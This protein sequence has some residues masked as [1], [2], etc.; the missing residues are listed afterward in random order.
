M[1]TTLIRVPHEAFGLPVFG[2][3]LALFVWAVFGLGLMIWLVR[4]KGCTNETLSYLPVLAVV[5]LAIFFIMPLLEERQEG[6]DTVL[7]LPVRGYGFMV[8]CGVVSGVAVTIGRAR[9][10]GVQPDVILSLAFWV[11]VAGIVGAR[12]FFVIQNWADFRRDNLFAWIKGVVSLTEGGLVV[13]GSL[14]GAALAGIIF[15]RVRKLKFLAMADMAAPAM[16]LGLALGRIGCLL[17][18]CCYGDVCEVDSPFHSLAITFPREHD[19]AKSEKLSVASRD[20][21][22]PYGH[23]RQQGLFHGIRLGK[24]EQGHPVVDEVLAQPGNHITLKKGD[25]IVEIDR[26]TTQTLEVAQRQ[27][28]RA[29]APVIIKTSDDNLHYLTVGKWPARSLPV[30]PTQIFSA[31]NAGL[32][33][34][35]LWSFYPLRRRDGEVFV[36]L[37]TVYP[38]GRFLLESI[39]DDVPGLFGTPLTISQWV[40]IV[41]FVAAIALWFFYVSRQPKETAFAKAP[42]HLDGLTESRR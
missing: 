7:G 10:L 11:F 23:Q 13:Y 2:F 21:S 15:V 30:Y 35:V 16:M 36:L 25:R 41:S 39:R 24:D 18:G 27:F 17:N 19:L 6:S 37:F 12:L 20:N 40:S 1:R 22:P 9:R 14:I 3:G 26:K 32:L 8:L 4:K 28:G 42:E 38:I 34:L 33:F 5:G 29:L 31:V